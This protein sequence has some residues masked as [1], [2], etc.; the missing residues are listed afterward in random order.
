MYDFTKKKFLAL[1]IKRQHKKCAE[2]LRLVYDQWMTQDW[3]A[4]WQLYQ[5]LLQWMNIPPCETVTIKIIADQYHWHQQQAQMSK[6]EHHLL[7]QI[8]KG[9]R[10]QGEKAWPIAIYLDHLRSAHNVGSIIRTTEALSLGSLY[11]SPK[12]PFITHKQVQDTAMGT[13]QWVACYQGVALSTLPRPIIVLE[14][15]EEA[16]PLYDFIFPSS[17]TLVVGNEEYGCSDETLKLADYL[18]EIPLRGHKNSLNV[19]N[20]FAMAAGEIIRQKRLNVLK[21]QYD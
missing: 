12:T 16:T 15:S 9:D 10:P 19:A 8:R 18:V 13:I 17:F 4:N 21:D 6:K 14:T 5:Q 11:F 2:L 7:P 1:P 20:A 3:E